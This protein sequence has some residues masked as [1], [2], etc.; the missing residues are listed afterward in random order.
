MLCSR[1]IA[2]RN[3]LVSSMDCVMLGDFG[4]SRYMEDSSYY[5]GARTHT[6]TDTVAGTFQCCCQR[7]NGTC[8]EDLLK[9]LGSLHS[10]DTYWRAVVTATSND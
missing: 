1:D 7:Y 2:A 6:H 8:T 5:K 3:V 4:L 10:I 9:D